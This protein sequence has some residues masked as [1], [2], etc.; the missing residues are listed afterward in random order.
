[1][2]IAVLVIFGLCFGSFVNALGWR[3]HKQLNAKKPNPDLSIL[4]GRSMCPHC[5]HTLS[6]VD[7]LPV[8]SWLS[9]G[10]K[11]RFCRKPISWQYPVVEM[12]TAVLFLVSYIY[13][14]F[15]LNGVESIVFGSWLVMLVG[16]MAPGSI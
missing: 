6:A 13:W 15:T 9:L 4:K 8:V 7:L 5:G 1:M 14:P 11:C 2:I 12:V 3:L 16:F 10:G